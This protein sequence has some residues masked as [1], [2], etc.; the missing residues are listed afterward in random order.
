MKVDIIAIILVF[1]STI[2]GAFGSLYL[3]KGSVKFNIKS[4]FNKKLI[5]GGAIYGLSTIFF[6][7]ALKRGD[8]SILYPISALSYIWISLLSVKV[9]KEKMNKF[10]IIGI[11]LIMI[12]V[13]IITL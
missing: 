1:I 13:V 8:V 6:V 7:F 5:F 9:L 2:L 10:K 3:K 11:V 12:G 4:L